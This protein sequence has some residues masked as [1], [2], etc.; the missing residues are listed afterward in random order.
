MQ[1]VLSRLEAAWQRSDQI[2]DLLSDDQLLARPIPLRHPFL[3]YLGHLPA[4]GWNQVCGGMLGWASPAP[5]FDELF[6]RGIDPVG[7]ERVDDAAQQEWPAVDEILAYR[8][9]VRQALRDAAEEVEARASHDPLAARGRVYSLVLEHELMHQETL[10]YMLQEMPLGRLRRPQDMPPYRFAGAAEPGQV[11]V[12]A[13]RVRLGADFDEVDFGWDNE[14]S[15]TLT[16]VDGF[17]IDRTPVRNRQYAEFVDAGGYRRPE[18]WSDGDWRWRERTGLQ[19]PASWSDRGGELGVRT[20]FDW[21]P[22]DRV[23]DW[24][25]QVSLAEARAYARWRGARLPTEPELLW[26][27]YGEP[28]GGMRRHPWGDDEPAPRHG[29]FGFRQ[30]APTPVGAFPDGDSAW[31]VAELVGNGWEWTSTLFA[32]YPGFEAYIPT[33]PGY[34][35]DFFDARHFVMHGASWATPE[36]LIRR[37]FRNWFQDRYPFAFA[38]F[39]LVNA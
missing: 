10:Q 30:W 4:F 5:V 16:E 22:M 31:G 6:E 3:F 2:F 32:P 21:L 15:A 13:G 11:L 35:A 1:H 19:R 28:S 39:R 26:A 37:S 18:L 12:P 20:L 17:T 23:V 9:R 14:F 25:V 7:V 33:Y 29:N 24:P 8:D 34:S 27:A 38:T 36:G